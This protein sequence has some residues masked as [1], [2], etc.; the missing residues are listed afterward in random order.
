M[1]AFRLDL[2]PRVYRSVAQRPSEVAV[3]V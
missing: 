3:R 2:G 1:G